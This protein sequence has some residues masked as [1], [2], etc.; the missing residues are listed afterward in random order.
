[1]DKF[2]HFFSSPDFHLERPG[3]CQSPVAK[4]RFLVSAQLALMVG[5]GI[6]VGESAMHCFSTS[7]HVSALAGSVEV[8]LTSR[9]VD[10][11]AIA[12]LKV[13]I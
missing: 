6:D 3:Y 7:E 5:S 9:P 1:M 12:E 8:T 4:H 11:I 10:T 2:G 13:R